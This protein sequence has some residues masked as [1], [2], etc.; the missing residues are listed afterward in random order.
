VHD[1]S[2]NRPASIGRLSGT[3]FPHEHPRYYRDPSIDKQHR[4]QVSPAQYIR[5]STSGTPLPAIYAED[6]AFQLPA[7]FDPSLSPRHLPPVPAQWAGTTLQE[8]GDIIRWSGI[9]LLTQLPPSTL[10]EPQ[11]GFPWSS[12]PASSGSF[13]PSVHNLEPAIHEAD[14]AMAGSP[15]LTQGSFFDEWQP[16]GHID[17]DS[18]FSIPNGQSSPE[19]SPL[20]A[21]GAPFQR[22]PSQ[23][24]MALGKQSPDLLEICT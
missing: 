11:W 17:A 1:G 5:H 16:G 4:R 23:P 15:E 3:T 19:G 22:L 12:P 7:T 21:T 9:D 18:W 2:L 6:C 13:E 10:S 24:V 20:L 14:V 8:G